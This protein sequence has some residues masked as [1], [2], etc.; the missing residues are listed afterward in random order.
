MKKICSVDDCNKFVFGNGYCSKHYTQILRHGKI[1]QETRY[2]KNKITIHNSYAIVELRNIRNIVVGLAKIDI[3]D[4]QKC[5]QHKWCLKREKI[6]CY[7]VTMINK[8]QT[9]LHRFLFNETDPKIEIDHINH[10]TLDNRKS[11]LRSVSP[12]QNRRNM[13]RPSHNSSGYKGVYWNGKKRPWVAQIKKSRQTKYLGSFETPEDA[14]TAYNNAAIDMF[15]E[16]AC[17]NEI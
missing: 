4:I 17:L 5:S 1:F 8:K 3:D 16:Y 12:K 13:Q 9:R 11:N 6:G 14:A 10:D 15:G 2:C 7:V